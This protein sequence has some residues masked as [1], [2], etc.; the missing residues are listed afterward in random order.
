MD[1]SIVVRNE[2]A[3]RYLLGELSPAEQEWYEKHFFDCERCFME[4]RSLQAIQDTLRAVPPV[5]PAR[6]KEFAPNPW[7]KWIAAGAV[8]ASLVGAVLL[9]PVAAP[10]RVVGNQISPAP[11]TAMPPATLGQ[12]DADA[13]QSP[14][15]TVRPSVT[16]A[17]PSS[18]AA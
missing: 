1:C 14:E 11:A 9:R 3:E 6:R 4:L 13:G 15:A 2:L 7:W 18:P 5:V 10:E 16:A 12:V 8:A 17:P